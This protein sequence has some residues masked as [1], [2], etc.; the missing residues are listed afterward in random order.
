MNASEWT[1][2]GLLQLSGGYW[3]TCAL[4]AGVKLDIFSLLESRSMTAHAIAQQCN[5]DQ[6]ATTMLL[7]ALSALGLL[8]K[9]DSEYEAIPF[10]AAH[11]TKASPGYLG[12]IIMHHHHLMSGW[13]HLDDAVKDGGPVRE[14]VSHGD[15]ETVRESFLMGM[16]NLASQLAPG[17]AQ[18]IDLSGCRRLLDLGGGPGTYSIHFCTANPE[19]TAVVY[20]L[21]TTRSFAESTIDR[22][23]LAQRISFV[24]GDYHIDPL[25]CGFDVAWLSHV[26]H[27][28]GP[29]ACATLIRE[30]VAALDP[31]GRLMIQEFI[32][33]DTKDGPPFPAL[34]SLNMLIGTKTGQSYS[35][36]ELAT[37]MAEAGVT[38]IERLDITLPNGA[39]IMSGRKA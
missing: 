24:S 34:F 3:S 10:A 18:A 16:F 19:L 17:I 2:S 30:A 23:G 27:S 28:D 33:D 38:N 29:E 21:P 12:H 20:D 13:S 5:C 39:G 6:R 26:L 15:D 25:P 9:S 8:K 37:M 36:G 32:L 4:H 7:D 35:Q 1:I 31:G 14:S 11:L 22:F